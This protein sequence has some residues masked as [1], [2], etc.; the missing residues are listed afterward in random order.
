ME[1]RKNILNDP[2]RVYS[3]NKQ[4]AEKKANGY[5]GKT[6]LDC[7]DGRPMK[8]VNYS[9]ETGE[10]R[11]KVRRIIEK[12]VCQGIHSSARE[13]YGNEA[14]ARERKITSKQTKRICGYI[15]YSF[16]V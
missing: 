5:L 4:I 3:T 10:T 6:A 14:R 7:L 13:Y 9:L 12:R 2:M 1:T 11:R 16:G 15:P 8:G